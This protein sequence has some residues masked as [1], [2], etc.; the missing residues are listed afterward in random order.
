MSTVSRS[1]AWIVG[2]EAH[3]DLCDV[4]VASPG[5]RRPAQAMSAWLRA[6]RLLD[7]VGVIST[8]RAWTGGL[9]RRLDYIAKSACTMSLR[10]QYHP[11]DETG[12][13]SDHRAV[14]ARMKPTNITREP[15][16]ERSRY[17]PW[18]PQ[19]LHLYWEAVRRGVRGHTPTTLMRWAKVLH[20]AAEATRSIAQQEVEEYLRQVRRELQVL[21]RIRQ[22]E[23]GPEQ[24]RALSRKDSEKA[25]CKQKEDH[26]GATAM[27]CG[28][29]GGM[30]GSNAA[31]AEAQ[32]CGE[33]HHLGKRRRTHRRR[34]TSRQLRL[35]YSEPWARSK[36][37]RAHQVRTWCPTRCSTACRR[38][39][40][41]SLPPRWSRAPGD[42]SAT[43]TTLTIAPSSCSCRRPVGRS[44]S[45]NGGRTQW[46]TT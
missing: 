20:D 39:S 15:H 32:Y 37:D 10:M 24:R 31:R 34:R 9:Q 33:P 6:E 43:T 38:T 30:G 23:R 42:T 26:E 22:P 29:L 11:W 27:Q 41:R 40:R 2:G 8:W 21:R 14:T 5:A 7:V 46:R 3:V 19:D 44:R 1:A 36:T 28:G 35:C 16:Q 12:K 25:F 13:K 4:A 18:E 17:T 45:R